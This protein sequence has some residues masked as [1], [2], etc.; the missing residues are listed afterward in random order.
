MGVHGWDVAVHLAGGGCAVGGA[1]GAGGRAVADVL[2]VPASRARP[3][4]GAGRGVLRS[5]RLSVVDVRSCLLSALHA[6]RLIVGRPA[7]CCASRDMLSIES[8]THD[9]QWRAGHVHDEPTPRKDC[10]T[11]VMCRYKSM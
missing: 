4:R 1:V 6:L 2:R 9:R 5:A 8:T 3:P 11:H 7:P 10:T